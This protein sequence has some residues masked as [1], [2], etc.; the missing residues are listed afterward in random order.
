MRGEPGGV[1]PGHNTPITGIA[2]CCARTASGQDVLRRRR[3]RDCS[4]LLT[5]EKN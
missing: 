4:K 2:C 3:G 5:N 1:C